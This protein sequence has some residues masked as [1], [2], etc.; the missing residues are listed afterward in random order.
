MELALVL[1]ALAAVGALVGVWW[2]RK[3]GLPVLD[4]YV[5]TLVS[6][7]TFEGLLSSADGGVLRFVD[8]YA[9][10]DKSRIKV[11]GELFLDR[12]NVAYMQK[13]GGGK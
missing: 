7:E 8:A 10:D 6:G 3:R 9:L 11:D 13:P 1:V 12:V 4:R 5:V 2:P